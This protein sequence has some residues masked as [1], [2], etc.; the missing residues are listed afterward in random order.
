MVWLRPHCL[1]DRC[2]GDRCRN[3]IQQSSPKSLGQVLGM[4]LAG[5]LVGSGLIASLAEAKTRTSVF[6]HRSSRSVASKPAPTTGK[7]QGGKLQANVK[8]PTKAQTKSQ[9]KSQRSPQVKAQK[10]MP[11]RAGQPPIAKLQQTQTQTLAASPVPARPSVKTISQAALPIAA[12]N[13]Q[14]RSSIGTLATRSYPQDWCLVTAGETTLFRDSQDQFDIFCGGD[15]PT[16]AVSQTAVQDFFPVPKK[17]STSLRILPMGSCDSQ[18]SD[19]FKSANQTTFAGDPK[20]YGV[21]IVCM[22][23]R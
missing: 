13:V 6:R 11:V 22:S 5:V 1:I 10:S 14:A 19:V 12:S 17:S 8:L 20:R 4:G 9:T 21:D 18:R 23:T 2:L 15:Q 7:L 3:L 16:L